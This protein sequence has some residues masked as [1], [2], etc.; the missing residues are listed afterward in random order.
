MVDD[1]AEL[2]QDM[3]EMWRQPQAQYTTIRRFCQ[4]MREKYLGGAMKELMAAF[5]E[6]CTDRN[7]LDEHDGEDDDEEI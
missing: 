4:T 2:A 7:M 3:R 5:D 6:C 1:N